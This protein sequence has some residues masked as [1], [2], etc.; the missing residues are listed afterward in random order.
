MRPLEVR[1]GTVG[2]GGGLAQKRSGTTVPQG[3]GGVKS[4]APFQNSLDKYKCRSG[5]FFEVLVSCGASAM[6]ACIVFDLEHFRVEC[7]W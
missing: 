6:H 5:T 4:N 1:N 2:G 7:L 3:W